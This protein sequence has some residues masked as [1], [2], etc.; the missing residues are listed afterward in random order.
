LAIRRKKTERRSL[1]HSSSSRLHPRSSTTE[2]AALASSSSFLPLG[3]QPDPG[4]AALNCDP[5]PVV[6]GQV[7]DGLADAARAVVHAE[8]QLKRFPGS[9]TIVP[10]IIT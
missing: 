3:A 5:Q 6:V 8:E 1:S 7:A 2:T 9:I 10:S 4:A